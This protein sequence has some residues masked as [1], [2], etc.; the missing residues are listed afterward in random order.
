MTGQNI[1]SAQLT[2]TIAHLQRK[3]GDWLIDQAKHGTNLHGIMQSLMPFWLKLTQLPTLMSVV[4]LQ[5]SA[6]L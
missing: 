1:R 2:G 6:K 5:G 4:R 3:F